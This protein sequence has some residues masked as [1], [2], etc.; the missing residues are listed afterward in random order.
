MYSKRKERKVVI[1][2]DATEV[3]LVE[4][5]LIC[6]WFCPFISIEPLGKLTQEDT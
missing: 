4:A 1:L 3:L 5:S 2:S 6:Q